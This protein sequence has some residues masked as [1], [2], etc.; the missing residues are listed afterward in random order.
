MPVLLGLQA[1]PGVGLELG[2]LEAHGRELVLE[3]LLE[4]LYFSQKSIL[5]RLGC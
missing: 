1:R 2:G 3:A 4:G 5:T